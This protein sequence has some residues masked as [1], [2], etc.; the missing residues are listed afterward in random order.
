[1]T[2]L[3]SLF[4]YRQEILA[5][6]I[7]LIGFWGRRFSRPKVNLIRSTLHEFTYRHEFHE[8]QYD[9]NY[10][11]LL[12]EDGTPKTRLV[13]IIIST[14]FYALRNDGKLP[15]TDV[16]VLFNL[17]PEI[18]NLWPPRQFTDVTADDGRYTIKLSSLAPSEQILIAAMQTRNEIPH[19]L[20]SRCNEMVARNIL[21][22]PQ[23]VVPRW[24]AWVSIV[25]FWFGMGAFVYLGLRL[26][27]LVI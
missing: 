26:L 19:L 2:I 21:L 5:V 3:S 12:N 11:P 18:L 20:H 22:Q 13:P 25:F 16:E 24:R 14:G 10:V 17:R 8:K 1:M 27:S 4:Q 6:L 7:P 9:D 23:A 15:A